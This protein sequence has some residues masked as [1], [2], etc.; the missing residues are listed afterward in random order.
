MIIISV[1]IDGGGGFLKI[2]MSI[3]DINDP[4]PHAQSGL[5][6]KFIESG[7]K[8]V[9]LIGIVPDVPDNYVNVKRL[10]VNS[11]LESLDKRFTVA[12][13]LKLCNILLGMMS[14][15]RGVSG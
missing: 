15:S 6:K 1:G 9:F 10:W 5:A 14:H 2:C 4:F 11:G 3:F 12:T 7:V 8:R 13:D